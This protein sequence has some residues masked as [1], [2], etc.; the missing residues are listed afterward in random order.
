MMKILSTKTIFTSKYFKINQKVIERNGKTFTKDFIERNPVVMIIPYTKDNEVYIESQ[1]RDALNRMSFELVA[2]NIEG[3]DDPLESAKRELKE[4]AG[5]SAKTWKKLYEWDLSA[6]MNA[7]IH[8]F[9]ATDLEESEQH[10]DADEE[11]TVL[12]M[13]LVDA[14]KKVEDGEMVTASHLAALL[15]FDR[16]RKEGKL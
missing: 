2:G 10:L 12:K 4:E 16:L 8:L 15:L 7:K 11:I 1:F 5:L 13:P 9:A 6:S 3:S 14:L